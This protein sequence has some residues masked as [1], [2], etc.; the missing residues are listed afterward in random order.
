MIFRLTMTG[1]ILCV[2]FGTSASVF[3]QASVGDLSPAHVAAVET[4]LSKNRQNTFRPEVG[5]G[6]LKYM[7]ESFGKK[8]APNYV[9]ADLNGDRIKDFAVLLNRTG[10]PTNQPA[11]A[12]ASKEH[13][14][15]YPLTLVVFNGMKGGKFRVAFT[16]NLDGPN[17]AFINLTTARRKRLY[18]G[19]FETDSDTFTLVPSGRGYVVK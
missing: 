10:R 5:A 7:R 13:F 6:Y 15:N 2:L 14:P 16:Q 11:D 9:V 3:G 19:V 4:Y 1:A 17:A 8:F 18:Y 12:N